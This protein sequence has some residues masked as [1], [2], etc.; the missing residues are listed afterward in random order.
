VQYDDYTLDELTEGEAEQLILVVSGI[1]YELDLSRSSLSEFHQAIEP[2]LR[3][4]QPRRLP[5]GLYREVVAAA[6]KDSKEHKV[7]NRVIRRWWEINWERL[8]LPKPGPHGRGRIPKKV[9]DAYRT[10]RDDGTG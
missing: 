8:D 7:S 3:N 9:L 1:K 5:P 2:F 6:A 10:R 4:V